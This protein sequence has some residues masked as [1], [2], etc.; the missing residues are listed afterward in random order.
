MSA[1]EYERRA[2]E[3]RPGVEGVEAEVLRLTRDGYKIRDVAAALKLHPHE[4]A[5]ILVRA[6]LA[7]SRR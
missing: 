2:Q 1:L 3:H 5:Q 4:V 7:E 6:S